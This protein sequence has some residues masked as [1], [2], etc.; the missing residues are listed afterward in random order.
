[1]KVLELL[2][3]DVKNAE[4]PKMLDDQ[5]VLKGPTHHFLPEAIKLAISRQDCSLG[6]GWLGRLYSVWMRHLQKVSFY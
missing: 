3:K 2:E 4:F 6:L 1:M 5:A